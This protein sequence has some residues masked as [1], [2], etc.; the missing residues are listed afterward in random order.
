M[1][2][3]SPQHGELGMSARPAE[4]APAA[5]LDAA[6]G[7]LCL[8]AQRGAVDVADARFDPLRHRE[9]ARWRGRTHWP[10]QAVHVV[11]GAGDG[12]LHAVDAHD[13]LHWAAGLLVVRAH[14]RHHVARISVLWGL[15]AAQHNG[16]VLARSPS[17]RLLHLMN[18]SVTRV[19]IEADRLDPGAAGALC[20]NM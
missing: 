4:A 8:V 9:R 20:Y 16:L 13:E 1:H 12:F 18:D 14:L 10:T 3:D 7:H 5:A 11:V 2:D 15:A 17:D 6:E 19:A